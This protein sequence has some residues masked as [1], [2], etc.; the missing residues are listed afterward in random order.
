MFSGVYV[1]YHKLVIGIYA[2]K[3]VSAIASLKITNRSPRTFN[4]K[5]RFKAAFDRRPVL[6]TFA[7]K[8]EMRGY[9]RDKISEA[10][11]PKMYSWGTNLDE[12]D[13]E[14]LP[15]EFVFKVNHGSGGVVIVWQGSRSNQLLPEDL[16]K[17]SWTS[18]EVTPASLNHTHLVALGKHWL[19]MEYYH[20]R[21]CNRMPEWAYKGIDRKF[22]LEEVLL[23]DSGTLATDYKFHMFN[24]KCE[25]INVIRRNA[26]NSFKGS[27]ETT[28]DIFS[29]EWVAMPFELNDLPS[30]GLVIDKPKELE[31][32]IEISE[33]LSGGI[34]YLRVDL[35]S[36]ANRGVVV[37]ELT[38]YPMAG[39]M[40]FHPSRLN[41]EFGQRLAL[42]TDEYRRF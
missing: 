9:V 37:G 24:G 30:S 20:Y 18:F 36:P 31:E 11:L 39:Q 25:F 33:S 23:Q 4:E 28:S 26:F 38:N 34:D 32:M 42:D 29:A 16:S 27:R 14:E 12:V 7:D 22:L 3:R 2:L 19:D 6:K 41:M 21:G 5:I 10:Y 40:K 13:F 1:R 17:V 35:Y 8:F 15:K